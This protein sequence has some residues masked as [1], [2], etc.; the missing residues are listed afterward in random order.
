MKKHMPNQEGLIPLLLF[1]VF[2]LIFGVVF[3]YMRVAKSAG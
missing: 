2:L 3:V 1:F